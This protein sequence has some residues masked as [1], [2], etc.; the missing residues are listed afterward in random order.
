MVKIQTN[1]MFVYVVARWQLVALMA[2]NSMD[3]IWTWWL[4]RSSRANQVPRWARGPTGAWSLIGTYLVLYFGGF[5]IQLR[6]AG[7]RSD[8]IDK[9]AI[10]SLYVIACNLEAVTGSINRGETSLVLP[11]APSTTK[12]PSS[13]VKQRIVPNSSPSKAKLYQSNYIP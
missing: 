4:F 6:S 1:W 12:I 3:T 7:G 8:V 10:E 11:A 2:P 13:T 5:G 9:E